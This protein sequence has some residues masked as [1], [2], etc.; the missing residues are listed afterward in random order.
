MERSHD[1]IIWLLASGSSTREVAE[2]TGY[3]RQWIYQLVWG[4]NRIGPESLGDG[5]HCNRGAEPLLDEFQQALLW[6]ALS[7]PPAD[8]GLWSGAKVAMWM[9]DLLERPVSPQ[10]GWEYLRPMRF[11]LRVPRPHHSLADEVEQEAGKKKLSESAQQLQSQ[12]PNAAVEVWCEDEHRLG[13]KAIFCW[14]LTA[15][16]GI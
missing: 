1:Q 13:L 7:S 3:N 14:Q 4:Y 6:Q 15:L 16:V 10:R 8:G 12:H 2:V 9:S 11:R 5:R